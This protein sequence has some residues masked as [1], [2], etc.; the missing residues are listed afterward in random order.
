[1][2]LTTMTAQNTISTGCCCNSSSIR[3]SSSSSSC[4][5][6]EESLSMIDI[7]MLDVRII[8]IARVQVLVVVT[9]RTHDPLGTMFALGVVNS[10]K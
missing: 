9:S 8:V 3:R 4:S 10:S 7:R 6:N 2:V 1:M 5:S